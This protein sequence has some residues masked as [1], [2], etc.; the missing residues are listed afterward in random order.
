MSELPLLHHRQAKLFALTTIGAALALLLAGCPAGDRTSSTSTLRVLH[1][2]GGSDGA[3]PRG[4]LIAAGGFLYGGTTLGG[5]AKNGTVFRIRPDG[6]GF[7]SLYSFTDGRDN[8]L[9]N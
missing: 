5:D 4:S 6:T 8:G 3:W 9:G 7:Q 2:F 1:S